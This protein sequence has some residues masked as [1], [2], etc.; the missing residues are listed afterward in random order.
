MMRL[1]GTEKAGGLKR[2]GATLKGL[3]RRKDKGTKRV[4]N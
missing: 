2:N 4:R 3:K 1:W